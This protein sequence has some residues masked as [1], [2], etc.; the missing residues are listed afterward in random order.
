MGIDD[1]PST[2]EQETK[3]IC[4]TLISKFVKEV[5][6]R[7]KQYKD[8][9]LGACLQL[10]LAV[11]KEFIDVPMLVPSLVM[12]FKLGLAYLPLCEIGLDALEYW[13]QVGCNF[14]LH[15][16]LGVSLLPHR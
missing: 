1:S 2:T 15:F 11:P 8:E 10:V 3:Q 4:F 6:V 16:G 14:D 5:L 7:M 12:A 9:L 13:L